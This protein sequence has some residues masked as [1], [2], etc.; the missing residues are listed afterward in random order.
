MEDVLVKLNI[1]FLLLKL[2]STRRGLFLLRHLIGIEEEASEL[3]HLEHCF[4]G[5]EIWT[6]RTVDQKHLES[7][8]IWCWK[9]TEKNSCT[10][11]VR[12]EELLLRVREQGTIIHE[13]CKR[14][15]NWIGHILCKI[16]LLKRVIE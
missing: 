7:F 5:A 4:Y 13:T 2:H 6:L 11:H 16:C 10:D 3:L 15:E 9:R 12:N 1:E 8:K 14:K